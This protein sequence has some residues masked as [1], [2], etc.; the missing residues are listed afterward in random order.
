LKLASGETILNRQLRLLKKSGFK[1]II[2][3]TGPFQETLIERAKSFIDLDVHFVHNPKYAETNNIYS[4]FLSREYLNDSCVMIHGD[5]VFDQSLLEKVV[6]SRSFNLGFI[7]KSQSQPLKDFKGLI[8]DGKLTQV[9]VDIFNDNAYALQPVFK[10]SSKIIKDW[11]EV[12]ERYIKDGK[13]DSYAEDALNEV[14]LDSPFDVI[15][16]VGHYIEEIDTLD[17]YQKVSDEIKLRDY[18]DQP[19]LITRTPFD[20]IMSSIKRQKIKRPFIIHGKHLNRDHDFEEFSKNF[21]FMFSDYSPNPTFEEVKKGL[22]L[23][24]DSKADGIIAIGGGSCMDTA[25]A[26]KWFSNIDFNESGQRKVDSYVNIPLITVPTTAG[27]GSEATKFS[28]IYVKEK[29]YSIDHDCLLPNETILSD[30]KS[31]V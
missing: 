6:H 8:V 19:S 28:V 15:D 24:T 13:V 4:L 3:T 7:N 11:L 26:I 29:K 22:K 12:C 17:D 9:S 31:V 25:K 20:E 21:D 5:L 23:F 18:K 1:K 2:I 30:R 16:Y 10:V 14:L 27:T